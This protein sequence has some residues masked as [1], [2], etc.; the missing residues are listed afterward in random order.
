MRKIMLFL[1]AA[2][3]LLCVTTC[4]SDENKGRFKKNIPECIKQKIKDQDWIIRADEYC[5]KDNIKKIYII[6]DHPQSIICLI[7]Y[8]ENC[9]EFLVKS[10]EYNCKPLNPEC[11]VWGEMLP[12][13]TI[14]YGGDI[15]R[16]KRVVFKQR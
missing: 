10:D 12:D 6:Y 15:Y 11:F 2:I 3:L 5:S 7:G 14:E 1:S 16:F 8:D 13:G 9:D 4:S